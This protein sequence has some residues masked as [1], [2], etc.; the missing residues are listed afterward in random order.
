MKT[1]LDKDSKDEAIA[2]A[3]AGAVADITG[4]GDSLPA[5]AM[6]LALGQVS[7]DINSKDLVVPRLAL[8]QSV[9]VLSRSFEPGQWV[10]NG[11]AVLKDGL[12]DGKDPDPLTLVV[13]SVRKYY[14]EKL[15][16]DP[17]NPAR[18]DTYDTLEAVVAAGHW[19]EW[20]NNEAPPVREVAELLVLIQKPDDLESLQF[21]VNVGDNLHTVALWTLRSTGYS[22]A[23]KKILTASALEL[24]VLGLLAA[25]W[26][27]HSR[28]EEINGNM[29]WVPVI[30]MIGTRNT[31]EFMAEIQGALS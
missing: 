6:T 15:P 29:V 23:A 8:C 10:L 5:S 16:Y 21:T 20:R 14:E 11:E 28:R 24:K 3:S 12:V 25:S 22:R 9:G 26:N 1:S 31:P 4:S 19:I 18:P 7:G 27:L 17:K 13:L 2:T 30:D